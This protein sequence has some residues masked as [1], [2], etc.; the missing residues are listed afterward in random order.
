MFAPCAQHDKELNKFDQ[1]GALEVL[2]GNDRNRWLRIPVNADKLA[3][4]IFKLPT[5]RK[6]RAI[7][8]RFA[9]RVNS[10]GKIGLAEFSL[11]P[12]AKKNKR[13]AK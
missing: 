5:P 2:I 6:I 4:T 11:L 9:D 12:A 1:F 8:F 7:Q 13:N 3:P 10:T